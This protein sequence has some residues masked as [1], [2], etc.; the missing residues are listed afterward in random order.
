VRTSPAGADV[1]LNGTY[2]GHTP[3]NLQVTQDSHELQLELAG[4]ESWR[5][6]I[7]PQP[8]MVIDVNLV[9]K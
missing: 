2:M 8:G 6:R 1:I 5:R 3:Y 7:K 9:P 4:Y